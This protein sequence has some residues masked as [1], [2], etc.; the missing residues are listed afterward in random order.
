MDSLIKQKTIKKEILIKG[1]SL[2]RGKDTKLKILPAKENTGIKF[3]RT[4]KKRNNI[5]QARWNNV[6][7]T[8]MCTVISN[9]SGIKVSTIEHLM[10]AI[11]SYQINNLRIEINESEVPIL[12]GSSKQFCNKIE[13]AGVVNQSENQKFIKI[14][15]NI[16]LKSKHTYASLSPSKN[17]LK[18]SFNIDF[19]HPLIKNE[20]YHIQ[21]NKNNFKNEIAPA[22][23]FGFKKEHKK[24]KKLGLANGASLENCVV[25]NR[26]KILNKNG[27]RYDNEFVRH[28]VLDVCGDLYLAGYP[29]LG[30]FK[31]YQSGH[32]LNNQLLRKLF[33]N[34]SAFAM[35]NMTL[36]QRE[37]T[38]IIAMPIPNKIAS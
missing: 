31:G 26:N 34:K 6:T 18:V 14:L 11:A 17:N 25:I 5:I 9:R 8:K 15:N 3:I 2:H 19:Q 24:L 36:K 16:K 32:Y 27:L 23:T 37:E 12:D 13:K 4:D 30:H 10:A 21:V 22:R 29:I 33:Q 35:V 28:K 20:R 7:D 38:N 1:T